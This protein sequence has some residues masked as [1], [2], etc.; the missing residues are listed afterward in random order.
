MP[1][2]PVII[3]S[4]LC[5]IALALGYWSGQE[6]Q[7]V[8]SGS[9]VKSSENKEPEF[10]R[11][12]LVA[13]YPF[14][15]NAEDES[16]N[17]NDGEIIGAKLIK[18]RFGNSDSA[19]EFDG[20]DDWIDLTKNNLPIAGSSPRTIGIWIKPRVNPRGYNALI[21]GVDSSRIDAAGVGFY[22]AFHRS[23]GGNTLIL[24]DP[25][26]LKVGPKPDLFDRWSFHVFTY[27]GSSGS[28]Y[29][30][31]ILEAKEAMQLNT[32]DGKIYISKTPHNGDFYCGDLDDVFVFNRAL[33][34]EEVK[35]LYEF[36]KAN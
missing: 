33:S 17:G 27:D 6:E 7:E 4:V 8:A 13:Y 35:A 16:G 22:V 21:Y 32:F 20:I 9:D 11:D 3:I 12:G 34:A 5:V 30:D 14:N 31:G 26:H 25:P 18:D 24:A 1:K 28:Y 19:F 23:Q 10:L 2:K 36:E 15:G 29:I